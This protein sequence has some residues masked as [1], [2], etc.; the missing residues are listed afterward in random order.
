MLISVESLDSDVRT[1]EV[2]RMLAERKR[3]LECE[4]WIAHEESHRKKGED[5]RLVLFS[6]SSNDRDIL[7][8]PK[9]PVPS[10]VYDE[11][12][13][14]VGGCE[15]GALTLSRD[16]KGNL[17]SWSSPSSSVKSVDYS[18]KNQEYS[19]SVSLGDYSPKT[20]SKHSYDRSN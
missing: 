14:P 19:E 5:A 6:D 18:A 13:F 11:G 1:Q 2:V 7:E 16:S 17:H 8:K 12:Q 15:C 9:G 10:K 3:L 20:S 4:E